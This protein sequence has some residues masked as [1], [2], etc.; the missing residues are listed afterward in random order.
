MMYRDWLSYALIVPEIRDSRM[1]GSVYARLKSLMYWP[2]CHCSDP[3]LH[4]PN[5][6]GC[7]KPMNPPTPTPCPT[8]APKFTLPGALLLQVE[9]D[10]DVALVVRSRLRR[11][12]RRL[13][14]SEVRDALIASNQELTVENVA[15]HD[16]DLIANAILGRDVVP[17]DL[18][19]VHDRR[20][21]LVDLPPQIHRRHR[22]LADLHALDDRSDLRVDVSLV[23]VR[24]LHLLRRVVP[25]AL[26]EDLVRHCRGVGTRP[27]PSRSVSSCARRR[28][29]SARSD[30]SRRPSLQRPRTRRRDTAVP[31]STPMSTSAL[32][33]RS[34]D[35]QRV[36]AHL[37]VDESVLAVDLRNPLRH[38]AREL[39]GVVL[40]LSPEPEAFRLGLHRRDDRLVRERLIPLNVDP[41][42]REATALAHVKHRASAARRPRSCRRGP[43]PADSPPPRTASRFAPTERAT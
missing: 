5:R 31:R 6:F 36:A 3:F 21:P 2:N 30:R 29:R 32:P 8:D 41:G 14:E 19:A 35:D 34:I 23:R 18:D 10:V 43:W 24:F 17:H 16:D 26:V 7:S 9:N 40:A 33:A 13:E 11:R 25:F 15:R 4:M 27:S 37:H 38:V 22:I 28:D 12:Q 42:N 39:V 20:R 1:F